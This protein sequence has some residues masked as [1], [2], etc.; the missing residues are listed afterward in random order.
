[1][2][3]SIN[4]D[5]QPDQFSRR[6][7]L[8]KSA[9]VAGAA[10]ITPSLLTMSGALSETAEAA[11]IKR[12]HSDL[13]RLGNSKVKISRMGIG[14]GTMNGKTQRD[15]GQDGFT[16]L[17]HYC[18]DH[19]IRYIDTADQYKTHEYVN[20]A[21]K[22]LPREKLYIQTK[23]RWIEDDTRL[24]PMKHLDRFR[25]E[26]NTDYFDSVLIHCTTKHNWPEECKIMMDAF[27][28]AQHKGWL[29]LKGMSC[30]GLAALKTAREHDWIQLQ[31]ARVNPQGRRVD[32]D[33]KNVHAVQGKPEIA[34]KE[35]KA[36]H[37]KG[38]GIIGMKIIGEGDFKDAADREK[39]V[40]YAMNC[41]F[42]DAIVIGFASTAEVDEAIVRVNKALN[43]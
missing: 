15:L 35:I 7:F 30:H 1:V 24:N 4:Q 38:R 13:V 3:D 41:G 2:N 22:G 12:A 32:G 23:M 37:D 31:L 10:A 26:V 17:V 34:L 6:N 43:S 29:K 8:R 14:T 33:D 16:K 5:S 11:P 25:K 36:M 42:V 39:S 18:F 27:D 19:G 28:E 9:E 21:I 20:A 40:Q